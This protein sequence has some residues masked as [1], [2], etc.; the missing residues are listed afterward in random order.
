MNAALLL[1]MMSLPAHALSE[2]HGIDRAR[3]LEGGVEVPLNTMPVVKVHG[4]HLGGPTDDSAHELV[5]MDYS[6]ETRVAASVDEIGAGLFRLDPDELLSADTEYVLMVIPGIYG[7]ETATPITRFTTGAETDEDVPTIPQPIGVRQ[8]SDTDEWGDWHT[9]S[10][11]QRPA[12]DSVGVVYSVEV[13]SVDCAVAGDCGM[14]PM[15]YALGGA[16]TGEPAHDG[17]TE[18][19]TLYFSTSPAGEFDPLATLQPSDSVVR[20]V[21][22]DLSGN[23]AALVCILPTG[24][25]ADEVGCEDAALVANL[26]GESTPEGTDPDF[27]TELD[28]EEDKGAG[29]AVAGGAPMMGLAALGL[30]AVARRRDT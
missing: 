17:T 22:A 27:T 24:V 12:I 16:T 29:C 6:S 25:E 8:I 10:V 3:P 7:E 26:D 2:A 21:T 1:S 20:I 18:N 11:E 15:S 9:F 13:E 4:V 30:A 28:S 5:L 23:E 14:P 19:E